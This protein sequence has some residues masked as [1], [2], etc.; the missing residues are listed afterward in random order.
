MAPHSSMLDFVIGKLV[1]SAYGKKARFFIKKEIF[2][3]PLLGFIIK[4]MGGISIDRGN[5]H[6]N[7]VNT[8][9]AMFDKHDDL[10]IVLTPE[11]TRK[12][13]NHWKSGFYKIAVKANVPILISYIDYEKKVGTIAA[14][15]YPTGNY[16]EDLEKIKAYYVGVTPRHPERKA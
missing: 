14:K 16:D 6:N 3:I 5:I 9:A 2:S 15:M 7:V 11:G 8:S 13:V 10:W 4:K 1:T 12:K